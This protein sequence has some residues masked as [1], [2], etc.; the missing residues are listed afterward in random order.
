MKNLS[1]LVCM[2]ILL[3]LTA[4]SCTKT[5]LETD[6]EEQE[7]FATEGGDEKVKVVPTGN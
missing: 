2:G 3:A 5:D 1:K 7:L 4:T 6:N